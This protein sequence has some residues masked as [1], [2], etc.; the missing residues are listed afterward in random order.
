MPNPIKRTKENN[1]YI[2]RV[3]EYYKQGLTIR[4]IAK[5][6]PKSKSWIAEKIKDIK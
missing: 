1:K 3:K 2:D 4:D 5:I 6:I